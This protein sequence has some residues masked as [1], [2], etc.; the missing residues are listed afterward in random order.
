MPCARKHDVGLFHGY[1]GLLQVALLIAGMVLCMTLLLWPTV[2]ID[3]MWNMLIPVAPALIVVAP[4]LWR[5]ICPMATLSLLPRRF[6]WS[7]RRILSRSRAGVFLAVGLVGLLL[8]VPLR[9]LSLNT[10]GPATALML[11]LSALVAFSAGTVYELR[12]GW[13]NSLCPIHPA[14]KLYGMSPAITP[15]NA[16]CDTCHQCSTPCP[17]STRSMTPV[18]TGPALIERIVGHV[19]AGGFVGF[20][21]GWYR[22]PDFAASAVNLNEVVSAY[23]WPFA[24]G[25]VTLTV[26]LVIRTWV[27]QNPADRRL[28]VKLFATAAV[29]TYYWY[30]IPAL[31]GFGPFPGSGMLW[32]LSKSLPDLQMVS[33]V[34][35][36]SFFVWFLL[37]RDDPRAS[38]LTR[39]RSG[40]AASTPR[41]GALLAARGAS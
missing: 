37:L 38:W 30:R 18:V 34:L 7:R 31:L 1:W 26:Y 4:G 32:D 29:S 13:C 23:S 11:F 22:V 5:N 24:A 19:M 16:R 39:P 14:E 33:R 28:L 25:I 17:D 10:D 6:G 3:I 2:G 9:H 41:H 12:S 21:W 27:C 15:V 40:R 35:T 36:T 8:I 20:I